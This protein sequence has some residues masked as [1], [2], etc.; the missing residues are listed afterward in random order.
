LVKAIYVYSQDAKFECELLS[1]IIQTIQDAS[2]YTDKAHGVG[3]VLLKT[4]VKLLG[5]GE[6]AR[7]DLG[8]NH[9]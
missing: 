4:D 1:Q 6:D 7:S 9:K 5:T 3:Q 8:F 2:D